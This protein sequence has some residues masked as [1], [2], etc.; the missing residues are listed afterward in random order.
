MVQCCPTSCPFPN[1]LF[2]SSCPRANRPSG[3]SHEGGGP[4]SRLTATTRP[5]VH[6]A[7]NCFQPTLEQRSR[8][9]LTNRYK[10]KRQRDSDLEASHQKRWRQGGR[11][12]LMAR[13]LVDGTECVQSLSHAW[14]ECSVGWHSCGCWT[15]WMPSGQSQPLSLIMCASSMMYLPSLYF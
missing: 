7:H 10:A 12:P 1:P 2:C 9:Q 5:R 14:V 13:P 4:F 6:S 8:D 11:V 15:G 3:S